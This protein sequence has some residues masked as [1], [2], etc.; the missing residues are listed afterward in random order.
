VNANLKH[1]MNALKHAV[2]RA[3]GKAKAE[4]T[5]S[6]RRTGNVNVAGRANVV[7]ARTSG[8]S[9][10]VSGASAKQRVRIRQQGAETVE[11]YDETTSTF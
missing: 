8:E 7:I 4:A 5:R 2:K 3:A 10:S 6:G 11:E 1:E 9:D